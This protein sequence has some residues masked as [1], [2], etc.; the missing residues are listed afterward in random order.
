MNILKNCTE[1]L[2]DALITAKARELSKRN[3][4]LRD[5]FKASRSWL[6][7]FKKRH[8]IE[9][10]ANSFVISQSHLADPDIDISVDATSDLE[11]Q[12]SPS[13]S[14]RSTLLPQPQHNFA[15]DPDSYESNPT[16]E[17]ADAAMSTILRFVSTNTEVYLSEHIMEGIGILSR[18]FCN[19]F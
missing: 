11:I 8:G 3:D 1:D 5:K 14:Q 15:N 19:G 2:N 9:C 16:A 10:P 12:S 6:C 13:P 7:N 17:E 4:E 18:R